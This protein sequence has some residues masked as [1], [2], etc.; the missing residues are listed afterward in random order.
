MRVISGKY[1]GRKI[2]G[3]DIEGTRPTQDR[4]KESLFAMIQEDIIDSCVLDLF[5]GSGNLG[6][7]ALSNGANISYFVDSNSKCIDI[8]KKNTENI[9]NCVILNKDYLDALY[10]FKENNIKFN[11]IFLDPPYRMNIVGEIVEYIIDNK[12][13]NKDGYIICQFVRGNLEKLGVTDESFA[14]DLTVKKN[15]SFGNS[16]VL[17][18]QKK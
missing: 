18:Y 13:I 9:D 4:V 6:I 15:Y 16:E 5:A 7:E 17:I 14:N 1:K 2:E 11:I 3:F 8:I 12:M 10:Y